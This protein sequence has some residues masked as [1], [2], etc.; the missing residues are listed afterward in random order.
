MPTKSNSD[1][2]IITQSIALQADW[3]ILKNDKKATWQIKGHTLILYTCT[4]I[5]TC[6]EENPSV[7]KQN[8]QEIV[9]STANCL[10]EP[11]QLKVLPVNLEILSTVRLSPPAFTCSLSCRLVVTKSSLGV[12]ISYKGVWIEFRDVVFLFSLQTVCIS[13]VNKKGSAPYLQRLKTLKSSMLSD[14]KSATKWGQNR[15]RP[16]QGDCIKLLQ[17]FLT[18]TGEDNINNL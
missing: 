2:M 3:L 18:L 5:P 9:N 6:T 16:T 14:Q 13:N 4:E 15:M 8:D 17:Y 7:E 11:V 12:E 10:Y 1:W